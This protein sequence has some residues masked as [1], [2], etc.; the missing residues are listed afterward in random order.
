[1][2]EEYARHNGHADLL[3][4]RID[5]RVGQSCTRQIQTLRRVTVQALTQRE[6]GKV[7]MPR[8]AGAAEAQWPVD[9][10]YR[11]ERLPL[12]RLRRAALI[13]A[14]IAAPIVLVF[15]LLVGLAAWQ[16]GWHLSGAGGVG[17]VAFAP[18]LHL[19]VSAVGGAGQDSMDT[20][21]DVTDP[22]RPR[23]LSAF[24]GSDPTV[25]SPDGRIVATLSYG[26]QPV[27]WNVADPGRPARIAMMPGRR[28]AAVG[29][30]LLA[31]RA[32]PRRRLY[33]PDLPVGCGQRDPAPAAGH[34]G[35]LG[36]AGLQRGVL[37][38][39]G[40]RVL[41]RRAHPGQRHRHR[42]GHRV[43]RDRSGPHRPHRHP[44]RP[45]RLRPGDRVLP[46]GGLLAVV[47]YHGTVLVS[48]LA[49]PARPARTATVSGIMADA[50][51]PD[52]QLQ[53]P[54]AP[55]CPLCSPANYAVVFTPDG[56]TLT[57]VVARQEG[58]VTYAYSIAARDTVFTWNLTKLR[59]G[60]RRHHRHPQRQGQPAHPGPQRPHR[61]RWLA[62]QQ[63]GVPMDAAPRSPAA[64]PAGRRAGESGA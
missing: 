45:A 23:Q 43:E 52:G 56:R 18:G 37:Q 34:P 19:L 28:P 64:D 51:Y 53:H 40:H 33:R 7:F 21:W 5:G 8:R 57:V 55:P 27:L 4:E 14:A 49:D 17:G 41:P 30:G 50:L 15:G 25:L 29:R 2:I 39:A 38:P 59:R 54:D 62:H 24:Q 46:R 35:R 20:V 47:T 32:G 44:D 12:S 42:P 1:M 3:R 10:A 6:P 61:G 13:S 48:S 11:T 16:D 63:R 31:R 9:P 36:A 22:A 60:Q 58:N 26:G